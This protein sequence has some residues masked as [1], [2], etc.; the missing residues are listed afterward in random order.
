[1]IMTL[2]IMI[3]TVTTIIHAYDH[4]SDG[5]NQDHNTSSVLD[6]TTHMYNIINIMIMIVTG[7]LY[8]PDHDALCYH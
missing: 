1:M 6:V 4:D 5:D 8:M 3:R 7:Y 2:T